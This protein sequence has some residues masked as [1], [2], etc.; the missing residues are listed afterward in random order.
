MNFVEEIPFNKLKV[1]LIK[2]NCYIEWF[3]WIQV[4]GLR[5]EAAI[6]V[7]SYSRIHKNMKM[8]IEIWKNELCWRDAIQQVAAGIN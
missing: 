7:K 8:I 1:K 2:F 6:E 3:W 5:K 4:D